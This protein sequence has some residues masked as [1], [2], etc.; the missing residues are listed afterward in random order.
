MKLSVDL[1]LAQHW[2]FLLCD[3]EDND[4]EQRATDSLSFYTPSGFYPL[5][6]SRTQTANCL[7][8]SLPPSLKSQQRLVWTYSCRKLADQRI[9]LNYPSKTYPRE[10]SGLSPHLSVCLSDWLT[11]LPLLHSQRLQWEITFLVNLIFFFKWPYL[12]LKKW[13]TWGQW[14]WECV[15]F[16]NFLCAS[17]SDLSSRHHFFVTEDTGHLLFCAF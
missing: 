2:T 3:Y 15:F 14:G 9:L 8:T 13:D 4:D 1:R 17:L 12:S 7:T 11:T 6:L 5:W 16:F 10:A